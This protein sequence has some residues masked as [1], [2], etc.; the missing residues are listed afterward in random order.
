[1][2]LLFFV[3]CFAGE[4]LP[5]RTLQWEDCCCG[6]S[7]NWWCV[8]MRPLKNNGSIKSLVTELRLIHTIKGLICGLLQEGNVWL[9]KNQNK[10]INLKASSFC[11]YWI[12]TPNDTIMLFEKMCF[13]NNL[14]AFACLKHICV[15]VYVRVCC[16]TRRPAERETVKSLKGRMCPS[17]CTS[18]CLTVGL[19]KGF[20]VGLLEFRE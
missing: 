3:K 9:H 15:N 8:F 6:N 7:T 4:N 5:H 1:M 16:L 19:C 10:E 2:G 11:L 18:M 17:V 20:T 14:D 12:W 13:L